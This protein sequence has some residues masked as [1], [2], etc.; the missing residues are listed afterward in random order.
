MDEDVL[1]A[2]LVEQIRE[3]Y[4]THLL[5]DPK[6]RK[7]AVVESVLLPVQIKRAVAR[8]LLGN[9]RVPQ[10]SFYPSSV[11]GLMTCGAMAGLV[12]DCGHR[13]TTVV[14]VYDCRPLNAY[15]VSTPMGGD[16]MLRNMCELVKQFA[17]FQPF[18]HALGEQP[19]DDQML[20]N[21]T[22]ARLL[23]GSCSVSP[24]PVPA[25]ELAKSPGGLGV[26]VA[27]PRIVEWFVS[28]CAAADPTVRL[29]IDSPKHGRGAL[30]IPAWILERVAEPLLAGD[31]VE[32]HMGLV[33]AVV[34]CIERAPVD[35]RRQLVGRILVVGGVADVPNF[36]TRLLADLT[37]RLRQHPKWNALASCVAAAGAP[38]GQS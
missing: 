5:V 15:V 2:L 26:G 14:P 20:D 30:Q 16:M 22:C 21:T 27:G 24:H 1:D 10:I 23:H 9:L 8:V 11:A 6:T 18:D 29:T 17:T 36:A 35:T 38:A 32:D 28:N 7:V 37:T 13:S 3:A 4:R 34:Q 25:S 33:D 12:V 31:P 19:V